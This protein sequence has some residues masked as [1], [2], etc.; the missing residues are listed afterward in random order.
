MKL[1]NKNSNENHGQNDDQKMVN[2]PEFTGQDFPETK[3][4]SNKIITNKKQKTMINRKKKDSG[5]TPGKEMTPSVNGSSSTEFG[6]VDQIVVT[7][8]QMG[9]VFNSFTL[10]EP[11]PE[12]TNE[13]PTGEDKK[14]P[15]VTVES[16]P[17][18]KPKV[19]R[20]KI[21]DLKLSPLNGKIYTNSCVDDLIENIKETGG[22]IEPII[23]TKNLVPLTGY[24]RIQCCKLL[25]IKEIDVIIRDIDESE[26][27]F[28]MVSSNVNRLKTG[29]EIFNE[30]QVLKN[31][32]GNRQGLRTDLLTEFGGSDGK[33]EDTQTRISKTLKIGKG[34]MTQLNEI[35][36]HNPE[37]LKKIDNVNVK[38]NT[39]HSLVLREQNEMKEKER[40]EK[41]KD[42]DYDVKPTVYNTSSEK[43]MK[44]VQKESV[45]EIITSIPYYKMIH[46]END[47]RHEIGWEETVEEYIQSLSPIFK[48]CYDVLKRTGSFFLNIGDS[49]DDMGCELNIPHRILDNL[50]KLGFFCVETIIWEKTNPRPIGKHEIYTPSYEFIFHLTKSM[51]FKTKG[52]KKSMTRNIVVENN[53][54]VEL[55][56][57]YLI[58][59]GK[60]WDE[61]WVRSDLVRTSVNLPKIKGE[62]VEGF[63][64]PCPFIEVIPVPFVLDFTDEGD[65]V[66]DPFSGISTVGLISLNYHRKFIGFE[67]N[68]NFHK[69]SM[70]RLHQKMESM[71][72]TSDKTERK[73]K[74]NMVEEVE[75]EKLLGCEI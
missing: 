49:R 41:L 51:D 36:R 10:P 55:D 33:K 7:E 3:E 75:S 47:G 65:T 66:L 28:W 52:L 6:K 57:S 13:L 37:Y 27:D 74:N 62:E 22:V 68:E 40:M 73:G 43:M 34:T 31:Y 17:T 54:K 8:E 1:S 2:Q 35:H 48:N 9:E 50:K 21:K 42:K 53:S 39:I 69:I 56:E 4:N 19:L 63:Y 46:Y 24:R 5:E 30:I 11:T 26:M 38:T 32:Y 20:V 15:T 70:E 18:P 67:T 44:Y 16:K 29:D 64:H 59:N 12:V 58:Y 23:V 25:E 71:G 45:D 14:E 72:M 60:K 61:S